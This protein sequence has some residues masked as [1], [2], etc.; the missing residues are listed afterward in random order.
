MVCSG[1]GDACT[2]CVSFECPDHWCACA[3]TSDCPELFACT[4]A[5][6]ND[7]ACNQQCLV[8]HQPGISAAFLVSSCAGGPCAASCPQGGETLDPCSE[9]IF[10]SCDDEMNACLVEPDC[11]D[12]WNC[13]GECPQ[14]GLSCQQDCYDTFSDGVDELELV[15]DCTVAACNPQC[16]D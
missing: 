13:L 7:E 15:L 6:G 9:C 4:N 16:G 12:L 1:F 2:E 14:L 3:A 11:L 10:Q 5:C 8:D